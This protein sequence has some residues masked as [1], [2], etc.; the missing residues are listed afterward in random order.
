MR[1]CFIDRSTR[2]ETIDDL[3]TKPRGGMVNS[4]FR[5]T[6]Y[7]SRQGV[8]VHVVSDIKQVGDTDAGTLW[9]NAAPW[10][11]EN[12]E[13]PCYD[14]LIFNRGTGNGSPDIKA[15]HRI[16]WT[17]DLP[18]A[19]FIPEA[20][21]I[22]AF[23][24][25]VFMSKYAERIWR[26]FNPN[27]GKS[28]LIQ[29]GVDD[30]FYPTKKNLDYIIYFSHPNRGLKKLPLIFD[31]IRQRTKR[32]VFLNAYSGGSMYPT[33]GEMG[34]HCEQYTIEY[35]EEVP[36]LNVLEPIPTHDI[37]YEIGRAGLC[38][39]PS[40]YPEICS[41]SVLQSLKSGTPLITTGNMG[42]TCEW[43]KH[44]KNGMLTKF[45]PMDYMVHTAEIINLA[46]QVLNNEKLHRKLIKGCIKT[47]IH[48]WDEIGRK[49]LHLFN[50][51]S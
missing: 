7:L 46:T 32:H 20:K 23:S 38:I 1:V 40:G 42:A 15:K 36:G 44:K 43:V 50:R 4:L 10:T 5:L 45:Y 12:T 47:K 39:M 51:L 21:T 24:A 22:K 34:D 13:N 26:T 29:N 14:F 2:L 8:K 27:I 49:W 3:K 48:S 9:M 11:T 19:G 25:T 33:D 41:N 6:D 31:A 28:F 30:V 17:H 16:L 35:G 37:A 18:H